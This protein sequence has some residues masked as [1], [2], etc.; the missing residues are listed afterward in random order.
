MTKAPAISKTKRKLID[1]AH[2]LIWA[3]SYAQVSVED[4]CR[5]A[6]V[7]KGSFYHFFP[8]KSDLA[9]AALEDH[10]QANCA[11]FEAIF[12][13]GS[14]PRKQLKILCQEI[15]EEQKE[16]LATTGVVCGC[17]YAMLGTQVN[18]SGQQKLHA[19]SQQMSERFSGYFEQLL[20]NAAKLGYIPKAGLARTAR[21]MHI[22]TLGAMLQAR[23]TNTL[24]AVG[25]N[26]HAALLR[27]SR[28]DVP[29]TQKKR[30]KH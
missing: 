9:A 16:S 24:D 15:L 5:E 10:W 23:L 26:L 22:Y 30:T 11:D 20:K 17:P 7:Q 1:A 28:M 4:I 29:Q 3:N 18:D 25:P 19:M 12:T 27:L 14:D 21:E 13:G 6:G 2:A 8:T